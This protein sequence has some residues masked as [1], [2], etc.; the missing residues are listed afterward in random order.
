M[1]EPKHNISIMAC[2]RRET[3]Y[4][5]EWLLYHQAIG[6]DHVYLYC[7]DEDPTDLYGQVLPFCRGAAP[8]VTFHHFPFQGQQFY[9]MMHALRHYKDASQWVAF[10]DVD[11]F[12]VLPGLDDI[13]AYL[14]RCPPNWDSICFNWSCFG[15]SGH[16]ERPSGSVLTAYTRREDRVHPGTKTITRSGKI[17]LSRITHKAAFWDSW[18][19]VV[20][21]M[22]GAVNVLGDNTKR[23]AGSDG[24]AAYLKSGEI[25]SRIR[26]VGFVNHYGLKSAHDFDLRIQRSSHGAFNNKL[27]WKQLAD[28]GQAEAVLQALNAV[29]DTY[30]ADFWH[31][32]T[33]DSQARRIVPPSQLPNIALGKHADQSSI[34]QWSRGATTSEDAAGPTS[35]DITGEAQ[36]HTD[37]EEQPWW[38]VDLGAPHLL[39]EVRLFNRVDQPNYRDQ[40]GA[41]RIETGDATGPWVTIHEDDGSRPIGGADGYPA[42]VKLPVPVVASRLR[43][44]ALGY[45]YLHLDQ[46]QIHGVPA[47]DDDAGAVLSKPTGRH[48]AMP[49][50]VSRPGRPAMPSE[51][52]SATQ[53]A[54]QSAIP[55]PTRPTPTQIPPTTSTPITGPTRSTPTPSAAPSARARAAGLDIA[56]SGLPATAPGEI[57]RIALVELL[58]LAQRES[59]IRTDFL[60][61]AL[62]T[63]AGRYARRAPLC[64][65]TTDALRPTR[66]TY[67][68]YTGRLEQSYAASLHVALRD[69]TVFGQ[70]SVVTAGGALLIDS[71]WEF[72][73]QGG[74]P[75][76]LIRLE[77]RHYRLQNPPSRYIDRPSLLMKRPFWRNYG[78]W[79]LDS[80]TLMA[81]LPAMTLPSDCQIVIGPNEQPKMRVIVEEALS[82]F[83]PGRTVIEQPDDDA[84]TF[85]R[86]HYVTP[87]QV[88]P[89]TKQ[90]VALTELAARMP[91]GTATP[92]PI[93][94]RRIYVAREARLGRELAN[95]EQVIAVCRQLGFEVVRPE[96]HTLREQAALFR[97]AEYVIGVKGA[98]LTNIVFCPSGARL[99]VLSPADWPDPFFWDLAAQRGMD[100]GEMFGS[101]MD[102]NQRQSM[103]GFVINIERLK[104][105]LATFCQPER[106]QEHRSGAAVLPAAHA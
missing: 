37:L 6:I 31:R 16:L 11:E 33:R 78:H 97:S 68:E 87:Q 74:T 84:W 50:E 89:L 10:L 18:D 64:Q 76:G 90:P 46:V 83:A 57:A 1:A 41:F 8:F 39:Y 21:P 54:T 45:T 103:H 40:L 27:H 25:Q 92:D 51:I 67:A 58:T 34:S 24:G 26:S 32:L 104:Q 70:G 56:S 52:Q 4:I 22:F 23:I 35:G 98:A 82:I 9:M 44:M 5:T 12:L 66:T 102:D 86:L 43:V 48:V 101:N 17:D 30:L 77:N 81:L 88:P 85:A 72:F 20:D 36:C 60:S 55:A 53:S 80:A 62:V 29:E 106:R 47:G 19:G 38:M 69:A 59:V 49:P 42:I 28:P 3:A 7:N 95:E 99:F 15:N 93:G 61:A 71:C 91:L 65:D 96:Q 2:A 14:R 100:Y 73:A 79:L 13:Q 105:N 63:T 75:P 94:G